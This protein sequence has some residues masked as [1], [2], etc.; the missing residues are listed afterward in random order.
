MAAIWRLCSSIRFRRTSIC[1]RTKAL[2]SASSSSC[3]TSL[4][5][6]GDCDNEEGLRSSSSVAGSTDPAAEADD[7]LSS[8]PLLPVAVFPFHRAQYRRGSGGGGGGG[9]FVLPSRGD[10]STSSAS[11]SGRKE[12]EEELSL[13]VLCRLRPEEESA[14]DTARSCSR[15]SSIVSDR[16][17]LLL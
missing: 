9:G 13:V 11:P 3:H 6:D 1:F 8:L 5:S 16:S 17:W 12:D 4:T 10:P 7:R 15:R 2:Y 14:A